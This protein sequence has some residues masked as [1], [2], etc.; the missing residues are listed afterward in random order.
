MKPKFIKLTDANTY[1]NVNCIESVNRPEHVAITYITLT[2]GDAQETFYTTT[3]E[4]LHF[5]ERV[6]YTLRENQ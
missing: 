4:P 5:I 6:E 1:L 3:E 2:G